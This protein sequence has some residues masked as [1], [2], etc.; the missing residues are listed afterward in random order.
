VNKNKRIPRKII[1]PINPATITPVKLI[2][3][4]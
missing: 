3:L 2:D 4:E 1:E